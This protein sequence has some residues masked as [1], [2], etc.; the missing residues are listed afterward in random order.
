M[1]TRAELKERAKISLTRN[2][3]KCILIG[4]LMSIF[5]SGGSNTGGIN[6]VLENRVDVDNII[7]PESEYDDYDDYYDDDYDYD[8]YYDGNYDGDYDDY[9]Y[10]NDFDSDFNQGG[11]FHEMGLIER[12][13]GSAGIMALIMLAGVA[14]I[15]S[16]VVLAVVI[17]LQVF[18]FYPLEVGCKRFFMRNLQEPAMV[19]NIGYAFDSNYKNIAK[20]MF[21]MN[22]YTALWSLLFVIPGIVKS[23]EYKMIPYLLAENPDMTKEQAFEESRR[24]MQGQKW[25]TFV[26]DLSFIGWKILSGMTLGILGI[27]YVTPYYYATHAALYEKLR[28]GIPYENSYNTTEQSTN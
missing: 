18:I 28:Y 12:T 7:H 2:Y 4:L 25:N 14:V 20:T 27:F 15:L 24:M 13:I 17:L 6:T 1:W 5:I 3:W 26:L 21:F 9:Y 19:G 11:I 10:D 22:L 23:Y 16:L 8:D